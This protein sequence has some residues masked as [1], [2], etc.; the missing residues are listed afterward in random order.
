MI[1]ILAVRCDS[2]SYK[3]NAQREKVELVNAIWL[4]D[5]LKKTRK[6]LNE[7]KT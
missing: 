5:L 6:D 2:N 3:C 4:I 7:I 1:L